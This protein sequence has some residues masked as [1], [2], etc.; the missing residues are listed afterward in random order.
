MG[1]NKIYIK[2]TEKSDEKSG[3]EAEKHSAARAV[4]GAKGRRNGLYSTSLSGQI[5]DMITVS[6]AA[7][8]KE[9]CVSIPLT[10]SLEPLKTEDPRQ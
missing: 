5:A 10:C 1:L 2:G 7:A 6:N 4:S 3:V 9:L 8:Q